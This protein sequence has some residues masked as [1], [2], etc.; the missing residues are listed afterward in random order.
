M[1]NVLEPGAGGVA[2]VSGPPDVDLNRLLFDEQS[3]IMRAEAAGESMLRHGHEAAAREYRILIDETPF[4]LRDPHDFGARRQ[5]RT[6]EQDDA[7]EGLGSLS[8]PARCTD[9]DLAQ[10]RARV[11]RMESELGQLLANGRIGSRYNTYAHRS[12][13]VRQ[14]KQRVSVLC[15]DGPVGD[16]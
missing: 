7:A 16:R 13:L 1:T 15:S 2:N 3:A 8:V 4:P 11:V 6:A 12:R 14:Q 10:L 5:Q 9:A